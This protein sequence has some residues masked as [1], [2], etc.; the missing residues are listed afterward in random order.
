MSSTLQLAICELALVIAAPSHQPTLLTSDFLKSS[1]I[2]PTDW[3]LV[4]LPFTLTCSDMPV[5]T[6]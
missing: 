1:G 6:N 4:R 3:E 2:V 5:D